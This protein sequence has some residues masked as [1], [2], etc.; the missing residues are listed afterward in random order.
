M[1]FNGG[2]QY[3]KG[4]TADAKMVGFEDPA[5]FIGHYGEMVGQCKSIAVFYMFI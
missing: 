3:C 4:L 5:Q 1:N 2:D